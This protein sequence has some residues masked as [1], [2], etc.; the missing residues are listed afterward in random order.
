MLPGQNA[1]LMS[2]PV[3]GTR[4]RHCISFFYH[5]YGSGTGQLNVRI[6]KY[7][8]EELLWQRS[9]EQS[10]AWLK[11]QVEYQCHSQHQARVEITF[12]LMQKKQLNS[13]DEDGGGC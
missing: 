8:E 9:G 6:N 10:I 13:L 5:M 7:G 4:G 2:R 1:R 3:R 11:A 12:S